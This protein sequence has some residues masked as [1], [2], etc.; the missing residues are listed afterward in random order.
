MAGIFKAYDIRGI[1]PRELN[2]TIAEKIG[3]AYVTFT[4]AQTVVIGLDMRSHSESLFKAIANGI[5]RQGA[6]VIDIGLC[7]S[8]MSYYANGKLEADGSIMI[9]ASHNPG[10]YNGFKFCQQ[11]AVPI[12]SQNGLYDIE[13]IV[14]RESWPESERTGSIYQHNIADEYADF[15]KQ[16]AS[17]D[18]RLK[19][20]CDYANGMGSLEIAGLKEFFDIVP[21]FEKLDGNFPNHEANPLKQETLRVLQQKVIETNADFGV[22]FDGDADRCGFVDNAGE[23]IPLDLF[24]ALIA[25][26]KLQE[27]PSAIVYDYRSS[28][29]VKEI[30]E[31]NGGTPVSCHPGHSFMKL[32]MKKYDASFGGEFTGHYYFRE[33]S[34]AESQGLTILTLANL[35]CQTGQTLHKLVRPLK[36]YFSSGEISLKI[37]NPSSALTQLEHAF[38]DGKYTK[39][40]GLLI[41]YDNWWFCARAS[42]TET[43]FRLNIEA[44]SKE[45]L[46]QKR[47]KILELLS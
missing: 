6:D 7:S 13:N 14:E 4:G 25:Q 44:D 28:R 33:N 22:A 32:L 26:V 43:L 23:I 10:I 35:L 18:R 46:D 16:F 3:R 11:N 41:E 47:A 31:Q 38:P 24:T 29:I 15:L 12:S 30:I 20:V 21:L 36:K 37:E 19:I 27:S 42:N 45:L 34:Y 9:T 5:T 17:M 2:E 39:T 1:Y 8:P 40:D